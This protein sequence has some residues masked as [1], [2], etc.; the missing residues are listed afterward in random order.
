MALFKK[1]FINHIHDLSTKRTREAKVINKN[2]P[3]DLDFETLAE[4]NGGVEDDMLEV[5][6]MR[7]PKPLQDVIIAI[8]EGDCSRSRHRICAGFKLR[9]THNEHFNRLINSDDDIDIVGM[10]RENI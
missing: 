4:L 1:C 5:M 2:L 7:A 3:E 8:A 9:E 6:L 10:L